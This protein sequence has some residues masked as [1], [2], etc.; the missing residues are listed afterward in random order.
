M[1][2]DLRFLHLAFKHTYRSIHRMPVAAILVRGSRALAHGV[3]NNKSHPRQQLVNNIH[4]CSHAE[5]LTVV[6][7]DEVITNGSTVYVSRRLKSG[8]VGLSK[9]CRACEELLRAV[10]VKRVVY[11]I[12][13]TSY[14]VIVLG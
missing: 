1:S 7:L 6:G 2:R 13:S 11:S 14:G 4:R 9:P 5:L 12:D 3:N 10:G 8:L